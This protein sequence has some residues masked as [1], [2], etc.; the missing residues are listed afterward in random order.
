M[1]SANKAKDIVN[2][3][4]EKNLEKIY[5]SMYNKVSDELVNFSKNAFSSSIQKRVSVLL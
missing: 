2:M 5:I 1:I 3:A 4:R